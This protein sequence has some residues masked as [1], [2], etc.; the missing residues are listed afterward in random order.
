MRFWCSGAVAILGSANTHPNSRTRALAHCAPPTLKAGDSSLKYRK[1]PVRCIPPDHVIPSV[2]SG[3]RRVG[4][5]GEKSRLQ[6]ESR[7]PASGSGFTAL[8]RPNSRSPGREPGGLLA[9]RDAKRYRSP[10]TEPPERRMLPPHL[11][12]SRSRSRCRYSCQPALSGKASL[13]GRKCA[14]GQ[15]SLGARAGSGRSAFWHLVTSILS[16]LPEIRGFNLVAGTTQQ[17]GEGSRECRGR[18]CSEISCKPDG[19]RAGRDWGTVRLTGR[20]SEKRKAGGQAVVVLP[21]SQTSL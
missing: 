2:G 18:L 1:D 5:E 4:G 6:D 14:G 16:G 7:L 20:L 13:G 17:R 11:S 19:I 21:I 8:N 3:K 12:C 10:V 15:V 9:S